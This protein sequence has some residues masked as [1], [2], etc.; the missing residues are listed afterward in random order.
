MGMVILYGL[1]FMVFVVLGMPIAFALGASSLMGYILLD[2]PVAAMAQ[3]IWT[4]LDKFALVAIPFF[5]LAG[6]LM[7]TSGILERLLDFARLLVGR[8]RGAL[9]YV[10]IVTSMLFGGINGSAVADASAVGSLLIPPTIREYKDASLAAAVTASSSVVGPIIPP[11]LPMLIYAFVAGNVSVAGLFLGGIVPGFML[12]FGM[13][14]VTYWIIRGKQYQAISKKYTAR[15]KVRI[16]RRFC[17]AAVLP[18]IMVGGIVGGIFSPTEAGCI[19]VVYALFVGFFVTRELTLP[20]VYKALLKTTSTTSIVLIMISIANLATW[21]LSLQ[22]V[23]SMLRNL[24]LDISSNSH[25]FLTL[26]CLLYLFVG[27]F[28][29]AAAAM[30]MLVPVFLPVAELFGIHPVHFGLVTVLGLLIGLVTPPVALC[31]FISGNIAGAPIEQVFRSTVPLLLL[32]IGVLGIVAYFPQSYLW[33]PRLF[34]FG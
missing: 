27:L 34:G 26:M 24:F 29:E 5:I 32:Q 10:N 8:I 22:G 3:R 9:F 1:A 17:V 14:A 33:V 30:I 23:P 2:L 21:W 7:S 6:D 20:D 11:S 15:E 13:M 18:F 31:L 25:V 28:I 19:A 4:G 12:G 16:V